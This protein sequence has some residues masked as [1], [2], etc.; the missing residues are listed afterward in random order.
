MRIVA[1]LV[2]TRREQSVELGPQS[3][4][5]DLLRALGLAPDAHLLVRR[6]LPI[7]VDESLAEG[8][9]VRVVAVASGGCDG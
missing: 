5:L 6:D 8:D 4:G 9:R 1:E 2:P 7:P 3:T